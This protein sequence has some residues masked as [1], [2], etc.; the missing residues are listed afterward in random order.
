MVDFDRS[1]RETVRVSY[2]VFDNGLRR[3]ETRIVS[4]L[5]GGRDEETLRALTRSLRR[6]HPGCDIQIEALDHVLTGSR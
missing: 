1:D 4:N 3:A 6:A 5:P 2:R